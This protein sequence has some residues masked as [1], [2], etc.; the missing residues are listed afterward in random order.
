MRGVAIR[1]GIA[2]V[3]AI[4]GFAIAVAVLNATLY[5]PAGFVHD[6]LDALERRDAAAALA[7][8]GAP[9]TTSRRTDLLVD[10]AISSVTILD[11]SA[12]DEVGGSVTVTVEFEADGRRGTTHFE[13]QRDGSLFGLFSRWTFLQSPLATVE[14]TVLHTTDFTANGLELR[15]PA[16]NGTVRYLAFA[17][18]LLV[19]EH[20]SELLVADQRTVL[21]D[22]P[23]SPIFADLVAEANEFF[24]AQVQEEVDAYLAECATQQVLMPSGCPFGQAIPDRIISLPQ[25][26]IV[27]TPTVRIEPTGTPGEWVVP[28][29]PGV[30]NLQVDVRSIFDGEVATFDENVPFLV[31]FIVTFVGENSVVLTPRIGD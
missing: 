13:L 2:A 17:P 14:I 15:I 7:I 29:A 12:G 30:A 23:G 11:V 27:T 5:S 3:V 1:A 21:V 20:E 19:L 28:A 16:P 31:G 26:S 25:W 9:P 6:Y 8:S 22:E 18:G 10:D 4:A 24:V